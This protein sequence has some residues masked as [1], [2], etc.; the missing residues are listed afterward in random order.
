M[1]GKG[2][3]TTLRKAPKIPNRNIP[4]DALKMMVV[5]PIVG[6]NPKVLLEI[7]DWMYGVAIA[8]NAP[9]TTKPTI[10]KTV[11]K[12]PRLKPIQP[13]MR[14]EAAINISKIFIFRYIYKLV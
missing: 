9:P 1:N 6:L 10:L 13:K 4:S 7:T 12:I 11:L 3:K 5:N 2:N 8:P 14:N